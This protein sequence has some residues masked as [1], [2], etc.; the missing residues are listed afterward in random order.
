MSGNFMIN[1]FGFI[2]LTPYLI[3]DKSN[4]IWIRIDTIRAFM[5]VY[6]SDNNLYYTVLWL[7]NEDNEPIC[8][9]ET[10]EEIINMIKQVVNY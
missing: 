5:D 8:V 9:R 3:S 10:P 6:D 1:T 2:K 4:C 7:R